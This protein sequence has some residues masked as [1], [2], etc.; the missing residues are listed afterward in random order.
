VRFVAGLERAAGAEGFRVLP[1]RAVLF[2]RVAGAAA[3]FLEAFGDQERDF[4]DVAGA[5]DR[6]DNLPDRAG[7][8]RVTVVG[9]E[10]F[11]AVLPLLPPRFRFF[12]RR[13]LPSALARFFLPPEPDFA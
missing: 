12:P 1:D 3:S 13:S 4:V 2:L 7:A 9:A 8:L 6:L 5:E 10:R 11:A